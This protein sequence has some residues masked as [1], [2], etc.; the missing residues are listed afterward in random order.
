MTLRRSASC[1][2]QDGSAKEKAQPSRAATGSGM[3]VRVTSETEFA[4]LV[5][6]HRALI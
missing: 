6:K 1:I 3:L 4:S 2:I 5:D